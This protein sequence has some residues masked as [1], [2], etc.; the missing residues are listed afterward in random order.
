MYGVGGERRLVE[1]T[2][3]SLEGYRGSGPVRIG[4]AARRQDQHDVFGSVVELAYQW[5]RRGHAPDDDYWHFLVGL[6]D[7]AAATW[8]RP[9]C[10]IWEIRSRPMHFVHSKVMCW[11]ALARG[12]E[13][14]KECARRAPLRRWAQERDRIR[15]SVERD[16]YD[17]R[18]GVFVRA[19]GTKAMD[20]ALL[21]VPRVGFCD[22]D[23]E[24]MVRTTDRIA[25]DL[26]DGG[27]LR[28][29]RVAD[30]NPGREGAFLPAQFWLAEMY[31]RQGRLDLAREAFDRGTAAGNDLGLFSEEFSP[32][33]GTPLGN[34][35]QALTHLAHIGAAVAIHEHS[36]G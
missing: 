31:A 2:V 12:I 10:G 29:Y 28:R 1:T 25:S 15:R 3:D 30:G 23:D 14:A 34:F 21:L 8:E 20:A 24:R 36:G 13:L 17:R 27:L 35:P 4:N 5:H 16:G 32:A 18:R 6:V 19:Y 22:H 7:R 9:D 33:T 26:D 11:T